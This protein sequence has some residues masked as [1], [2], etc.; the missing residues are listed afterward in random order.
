MTDIQGYQVALELYHQDGT[1]LAREAVA[2]DWEPAIESAWFDGVRGD[3]LPLAGTP[4]AA[5]IRPLWHSRL[6]EPYLAGFAVELSVGGE[7]RSESQFS[8]VYFAAVAQTIAARLVAAGKLVAGEQFSYFSTAFVAPQ[9]AEPR[10]APRF[11]AVPLAAPLTLRETSLEPLLQV[12]ATRD[13][14]RTDDMAAFV[15]DQVLAETTDLTRRSGDNETGGILVGH[16]CRDTERQSLFVVV[17]AQIPATRTNAG[18]TS[19]T[20]TSETWADVRAALDLRRSGEIMLGWWHSHPVRSWCASCPDDKRRSC[21][22]LSCFFSSQDEVLHRTVFPKAFSLALVVSEIAED[23]RRIA[24]FG[25]RRG[26][27]EQRG[28]HIKPASAG[29]GWW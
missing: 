16:L 14:Q 6:G 11:F 24:L 17:S 2:V 21:S 9:A 7:K 10:R 18:S 25:W 1:A 3:L 23:D 20:F 8:T 27:V 26:R 22:A 19:L 13:E 15:A 12:S 29:D 4:P 28:F 5:A